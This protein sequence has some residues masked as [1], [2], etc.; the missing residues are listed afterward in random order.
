MSTA[1]LMDVCAGSLGGIGTTFV[2]YNLTRYT[3]QTSQILFGFE[4]ASASRPF[5]LSVVGLL[6]LASG[7]TVAFI[8]PTESPIHS[9]P[10]TR[11]KAK[12]VIDRDLERYA[13]ILSK[14]EELRKRGNLTEEI[15]LKLEEEYV[16]GLKKS[17]EASQ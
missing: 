14:L 15:Y 6:L 12:P 4:E 5:L 10:S 7:L 3:S 17:L 11:F 9:V 1:R 2:V 13:K 8:R 16:K